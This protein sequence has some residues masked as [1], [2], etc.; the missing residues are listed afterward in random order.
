[1]HAG[2][3]ISWGTWALAGIVPGLICLITVPLIL[4]ALYPPEVC[5]CVSQ[6][7]PYVGHGQSHIV[8][9]CTHAHPYV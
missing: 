8:C 2:V 3:Q 5:V 4:Y 9:V 1:M 7:L 6:Y